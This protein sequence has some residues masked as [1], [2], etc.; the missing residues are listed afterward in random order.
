MISLTNS[1]LEDN[2]YLL[3]KEC[4]KVCVQKMYL[5]TSWNLTV[6]QLW[7]FLC[8]FICLVQFMVLRCWS[9][10]YLFRQYCR[11]N[12]NIAY[13]CATKGE[14]DKKTCI[15]FQSGMPK[16]QFLFE[17]HTSREKIF[18]VCHCRSYLTVM[19]K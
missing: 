16:E 1:I 4:Q 9:P 17:E 13:H 11:S 15:Y 3:S 18:R 5:F 19:Q 10:V 6:S 12:R 2:K 14:G 7:V 8:L